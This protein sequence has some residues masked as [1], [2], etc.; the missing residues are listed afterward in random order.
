[1]IEYFHPV[2]PKLYQIGG[3]CTKCGVHVRENT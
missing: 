2:Y 1:M 3:E